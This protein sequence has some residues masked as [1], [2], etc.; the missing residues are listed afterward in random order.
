MDECNEL[1]RILSRL[2]DDTTPEGE[3]ELR[4]H[5]DTCGLCREEVRQLGIMTSAVSREPF[6]Y[7]GPH[8]HL[9]DLDLA[10]FAGHGLEAPRAEQ[11]VTHLARCAECRRE[12]VMVRMLL[13]QHDELPHAA[14]HSTPSD[15]PRGFLHQVRTVFSDPTSLRRAMTAFLLWVLEWL[16]FALV[17]FQLGAAYLIDADALGHGPAIEVLGITPRDPVRL[18]LVAMSLLLL[19]ILFRWLGAQRYHSAVGSEG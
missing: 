19:G 16:T 11:T 17:M 3:A 14:G 6:D 4:A 9:A 5:I 18:W 2:D 10:A 1:V 7:P 12:F 15:P 13:E 8:E